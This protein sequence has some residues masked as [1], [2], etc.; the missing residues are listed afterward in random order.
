[1]DDGSRLPRSVKCKLKPLTPKRDAIR[2]IQTYRERTHL[3]PRLNL[4]RLY[5]MRKS[6]H[7]RLAMVGA[8]DSEEERDAPLTRP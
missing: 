4:L 8:Y 2:I 5:N 3:S 1:M 6:N 7:H